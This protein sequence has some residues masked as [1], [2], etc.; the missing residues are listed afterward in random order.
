[1]EQRWEIRILKLRRFLRR[2]DL[3]GGQRA[4]V[5][6]AMVYTG[7]PAPAK[8]QHGHRHVSPPGALG[9][10]TYI[11]RQ[12]LRVRK[13]MRNYWSAVLMSPEAWGD[14]FQRRSAR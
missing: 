10:R 8:V 6:P 9:S 5:F 14:L 7:R 11:R 12:A 2:W 4:H 13:W 1:M 3:H